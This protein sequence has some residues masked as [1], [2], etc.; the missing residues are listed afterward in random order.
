MTAQAT[1]T[2]FPDLSEEQLEQL[3]LLAQ[4]VKSGTSAS[5]SFP[6][7]TNTSWSGMSFTAWALPKC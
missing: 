4:G 2:H 3:N 6:E 1:V 7:R 5:T